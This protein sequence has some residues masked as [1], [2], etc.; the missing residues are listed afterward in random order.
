MMASRRTASTVQ[1]TPPSIDSILAVLTTT[2]NEHERRITMLEAFN[3]KLLLWTVGAT[4][5]SVVT[6]S[7][8]VVDT[9]TRMLA[10]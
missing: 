10:K 6:L 4:M 8:V 9:V 2:Q 5:S 1:A 3:F 7:A